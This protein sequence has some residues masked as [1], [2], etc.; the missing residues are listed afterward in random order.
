MLPNILR[1]PFVPMTLLVLIMTFLI[2]SLSGPD[3]VQQGLARYSFLGFTCLL[4]LWIS[5]IRLNNRKNPQNRIH[6]W[7]VIPPEFREMDEGQQWVT[8]KACRNVYIYYTY[9]LPAAAL[10]CFVF[11]KWP[12]APLLAIGVLGLGQY[13]VYWLTIRKLNHF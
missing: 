13:L 1:S 3:S 8:F 6:S 4:F 12:I 9:A 5:L 7:G 11:F 2:L 10:F